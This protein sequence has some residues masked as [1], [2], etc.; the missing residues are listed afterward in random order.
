MF[1]IVFYF[2][3]KNEQFAHS[4]IFG[5]LIAQ[6][7]HQKIVNERIASF[8]ERV[9]HW[10][11]FSQKTSDSLRKPMSEFPGLDFCETI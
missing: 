5:E 9:A 11:I 3:L 4:L 8:F 1:Y 6:V 10:L 2:I 7:A